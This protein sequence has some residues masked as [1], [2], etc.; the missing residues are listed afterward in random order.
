MEKKDISVGDIIRFGNYFKTIDSE[1][2]PIEWLVLEVSSGKALLIT[3]D[4]IDHKPCHTTYA[5]ILWQDWTLRRWLN[6]EFLSTAFTSVEQSQ[7]VLT[8]ISNP[9][10]SKYGTNGCDNTQD[11]IFLLSIEEADKYFK[12]DDDRACKPTSYA[13]QKGV[14][15][16]EAEDDDED[17]DFD[18]DN[19]LEEYFGNC[20]WWLRSPG[21]AQQHAAQVNFDGYIFSSGICVDLKK[22]GVRPAMFIKL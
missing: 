7:I 16:C 17:D 12:S 9:A 4:A 11:K 15:T 1:K 22:N 20:E 21:Y 14:W 10:N 19:N 13:K 2:E 5:K 18:E 3:K 8:E 6:N